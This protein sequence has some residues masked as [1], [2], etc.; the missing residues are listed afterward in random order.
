MSCSAS[1]NQSICPCGQFVFP[2]AITNP[3]GLAT[4][5]YRPGDY[6]S[7]REALLLPRPGETQLTQYNGSQVTPIW[8][9]GAHG[10]LAVQMI[11]WWAYLCDVLTFYNE[12]VAN[13]AYLRTADLPESV[14]R[15]IVLL[16]YRPRPGIGAIGTLAALATGAS[17][18]TLP[19]G[20]QVQSKPGPG[21]QP[22][23]FE[24]Q[25]AVTITPPIGP[26]GTSAAQGTA[27]VTPPTV[28]TAPPANG[29]NGPI[30]IAGTTSAVKAGDRVLILPIP[31]GTGSGF[32]VATV[33]TVTPGKDALGGAITTIAL[34]NVTSQFQS[35]DVTQ[36]HLLRSSLSSQVWQYPADP[37]YVISELTSIVL[38]GPTT[39]TLQIDLASIVRG[40]QVGDPIVFEGPDASL[41][42]CASLINSTEAVWYANPANYDPSNPSNVTSVNPAIPPPP[43]GSPPEAPLAIPIPHTRITIQW[44]QASGAIAASFTNLSKYVIRYG[45]KDVGNLIVSPS[46]TV[47]GPPVGGTGAGSGTTTSTSSTTSPVTLQLSGGCFTQ[48]SGTNVLVQDVNGNGACGVVDSMTSMHLVDPVPVLVPPLQVLFNLLKVTRGKTVANEVLGSG[49]ALVAGQDFVLQ[50]SPVTYLSDPNSISGDNYSS[51]V[52]VLVNQLKWTEVRSFYGQSPTAPVYITREDE[53]GQTHVVFPDGKY[54]ALLPTGVNNVVASYRYGSG[55]A[56]PAAGTLTVVMQPQPGLRSIVNPVA[57]SGG[58]DPDP[59]AHVRQL[60]PQSVLTFGRAV[61]VD[62]FQTIAAQTSGVTRAKAAV[63]FDPISQRPRVTVWVGDAAGAVAA[64]QQ[65]FAASA[66][67]NRQPLVVLAQAV[68]M[69]LSLSIVYSSKYDGATVQAA[70]HTALVDPD[71]GLLGLNVVGIGQVFYDSQVYAACLAVPGVTAVHS[72]DFVVTSS[73]F[74]PM[75]AR[76]VAEY[77]RY[78]PPNS[79]PAQP[80]STAPST[81][82]GLRHDPGADSYL[83]LPDDPQNLTINLEAGS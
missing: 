33:M 72:L 70:V 32:A 1:A 64:A 44:S 17:P 2:L 75:D 31:S 40:L 82:C 38:N 15:L 27:A 41:P 47:G 12:R 46:K 69:N 26:P 14:N 20:F 8:R 61:S 53:Q 49:N 24:L 71:A 43:T 59:P 16:G 18:F 51:T 34:E 60:A 48:P 65:A 29:T 79:S 28:Q 66:D 57:V 25:T 54:G 67:P 63:A 21:Q 36:F 37:F 22:Q 62:D 23:V 52:T 10:D 55:A 6:T 73:R 68:E 5:A 30:V 4:I 7:F 11:E 78:V 50:N 76:Y 45:W 74:T 77:R 9:P 42:V 19:V 80:V 39:V 83:F 3:P 35:T 81:C 56:V 13:Q 58:S